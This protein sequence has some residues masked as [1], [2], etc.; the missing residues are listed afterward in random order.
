M[1]ILPKMGQSMEKA[2]TLMEILVVLA[3]IAILATLLL[4]T[5]IAAKAREQ[6]TVCTGDLRQL[7]MNWETK[8]VAR[9][10]ASP[11]GMPSRIKSFVFI[12][13]VQLPCSQCA[14]TSENPKDGGWVTA[15][16]T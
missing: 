7:R 11:S 16:D 3:V 12:L 4:P 9:R 1:S 10:V 5:T 13:S 2:F 8:S 6:R 15:V 14:R